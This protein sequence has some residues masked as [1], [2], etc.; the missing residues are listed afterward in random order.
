MIACDVYLICKDYSKFSINS[1]YVGTSNNDNP[2]WKTRTQEEI[3]NSIYKLKLYSNTIVY[4]K[5]KVPMRECS[6]FKSKI[7]I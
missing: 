7:P 4:V 5:E 3:K 1:I 2:G 6:V